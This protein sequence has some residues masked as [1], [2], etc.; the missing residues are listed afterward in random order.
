MD[1]RHRRV[2]DR[3]VMADVAER[4]RREPQPQDFDRPPDPLRDYKASMTPGQRTDAIR[5]VL[6]ALVDRIGPPTLY[7][8][9]A[10]GPTIRWRTDEQ[11]LLLDHGVACLQ[12]SVRR[13]AE[14]ERS[15]SLRFARGVGDGEEQVSFFSSLP[16]LW[17][18]YREGPGALPAASP[19]SSVAPDWHRL[20]ESVESILWAWS[21]QLPAQVGTEESAAFN[22][23]NHKDDDRPLSV[24][25]SPEGVFLV[26]DDRDAPEGGGHRAQMESRGWQVAVHGW[27]EATFPEAGW[28]SAAEA[29]RMAIAEVRWRGARTPEDLGAADISC[30]DRGLLLLPGLGIRH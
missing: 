20:E 19:E 5:E 13:T 27:W 8:G 4:L 16:Y 1:T 26:V 9:S 25:Y 15:E 2:T 12:V 21:E 30:A 11:I 24:G 3:G 17:Q 22:I 29:A 28:E 23:V 7:G 18:L 6:S 14:L 10:Y